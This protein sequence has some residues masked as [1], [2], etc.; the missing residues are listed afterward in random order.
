MFGYQLIKLGPTLSWY[1]KQTKQTE[2]T[3]TTKGVFPKR[4]SPSF[5]HWQVFFF[6][7]PSMNKRSLGT[8]FQFRCQVRVPY[9]DEA[10]VVIE[11]R[12][13][14]Q[15]FRLFSDGMGPGGSSNIFFLAGRESLIKSVLC[16]FWRCKRFV[17]FVF[18]CDS[19]KEWEFSKGNMICEEPKMH[20]IGFWERFGGV[21]SG[22]IFCDIALKPKKGSSPKKRRT[23]A[24]QSSH[25]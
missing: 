15:I 11:V 16:E 25:F 13:F 5:N 9:I 1:H 12:F 2:E 4:N 14:G 8:K 19:T 6:Q 17:G 24:S 23:C 10:Y 21:W 18:D 3:A 20:Q 22:S 7:F